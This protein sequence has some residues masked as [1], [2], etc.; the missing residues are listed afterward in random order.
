MDIF[1]EIHHDLPREA[2]GD[3][4]STHKA[5]TLLT[6]LTPRPLFLDIGC[7]PG[8]QTLALAK[9]TD[10]YIIAVDTHQPFLEK[11]RRNAQ[12]ATVLDKVSILKTSM[13][14]LPFSE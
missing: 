9:S 11:L 8:E 4:A 14:A 2:P 3:N 10:G 13:F 1:F 6:N 7:G 12:E 5:F